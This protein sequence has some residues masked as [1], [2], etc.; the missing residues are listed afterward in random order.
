MVAAAST[1]L[2][3]LLERVRDPALAAPLEHA[4]E[5]APSPVHA[6]GAFERLLDEGG[7]TA[8]RNWPAQEWANLAIVCGSSPSMARWLVARGPAWPAAAAA[9]HDALPSFEELS[10]RAAVADEDSATVLARKLRQLASAEM[11]RI[12]ARDLL[13]IATLD[14][15]LTSLTRLADVTLELAVTHHR[16]LLARSGGDVKKS[17]GTPVGFVVIGMG[18]LGGH[19]LNFSSDIDL[20]YLYET[21]QVAQDSPPA[22]QFFTRLATAV[23]RAMSENLADGHVFRVDLRLR[24]EGINGE[25]VTTV[26][27]AVL[28]YEGWGDTWER[29]ALAKA[30]PVAGD[31]KLGQSYIDELE[32]FIYRRHLDFQT[33]ED[34]RNMKDRIDAE[35]ILLAPG[36]R[37]VKIGRGG[38]R[39][40]EFVAQVL[41]LIHGGHAP[42]VRGAGTRAAIAALEKEGFLSSEEARDLLSAY[43]FLRNVE[44]AIQ[45]EEKR[46]T[47]T[48]P[49]TE[50]GLRW[51]ARRL[52]YGTGRRGAPGARDDRGEPLDEIAAFEHDWDRHTRRVHELFVRFL[53]LRIEGAPRQ[54][55]A[56]P[57]SLAVLGQISEGHF[58]EAGAL[59]ARMGIPGGEQAAHNLA[60]IYRGRL[61]GPAS[62]QRRRAVEALAPALLDAVARSSDPERALDGLVEFLIRTGAHT[63]YL[64]LLGSSPKTMEILVSLFASSPY[65]AGHLVGHPEL[66]DSMVRADAASAEATTGRLEQALEAMLPADRADE[67]A[68]MAALRRFRIGELLRVGLNDLSGTLDTDAVHRSLSTIAEVSLSASA[69]L[70]RTLVQRRMPGPWQRLTLAVIGMGKL[71]AREMSYGSDLDL[72]F[73]YD[74]GSGGYDADAH[75]LATK[76][77]QKLISLL[78]SRTRDGVVYEVDARLRPSGRS[79]PLVT[80][81]E[82]FLEYHSGEADLWERQA[83][84]R[85]RVV[86]CSASPHAP[87]SLAP[88]IEEAMARRIW[89]EGLDE[90]GM[91]EIAD[92]R[93]RVENELAGEGRSRFNIKTGRGGIVDVEFLVQMLQLRYGHDHEEVRQRSTLD[94]ID[95]LRRI[96]ALGEADAEELA[97][98]YRFLRRLEA[99]LRL[100]R[101]RPVEEI[102]TEA[103]ALAPLAT[104]LGIEQDDPGAALLDAYTATREAV[105]A[106]YDRHFSS[107]R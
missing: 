57:V 101:D 95:A 13:G 21:D 76:W 87:S 74:S 55:A 9:Y 78:S 94:A 22:R 98:H 24:P 54:R 88:A 63:S 6:V 70:A 46:Q 90:A 81:L 17:D 72:I 3:A 16:K 19:E 8:F 61:R 102:G 80:S 93:A 4:V 56:D 104:R 106:I 92:L 65:L 53:E 89:S 71:G 48:L 99:R 36:T 18:K 29:G 85:A 28:Y 67:E 32:P 68:V 58:E 39:E 7:E 20:V 35:L 79:G 66:L 43:T 69:E 50:E 96:G 64:A 23:T 47:Q 31:R 5:N 26:D 33:I 60:R 52:G 1:R 77:V 105:R 44:H 14:E 91:R 30:R 49:Q 34:I 25:A 2:Q 42:A 82:R 75:V 84:I 37:N 97:R 12:G 27:A 11:Y 62:P 45:I 100:E 38:I 40:L 51:L 107:S 59:L 86:Y 73:V 10:R 83:L 41:Q 103:A 15:T